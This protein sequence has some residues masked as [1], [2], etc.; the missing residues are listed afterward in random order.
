MEIPEN[1]NTLG[2]PLRGA[3]GLLLDGLVVYG[4]LLIPIVLLSALLLGLQLLRPIL[5]NTPG[6]GLLLA[7]VSGTFLFASTGA[8]AGLVM[9]QQG[10]LRAGFG[11][12]IG[13]FLSQLMP[14]MFARVLYQLFMTMIALPV[15]ITV[16]LGCT[17]GWASN[18]QYLFF[19]MIGVGILI[20]VMWSWGLCLRYCLTLPVMVAEELPADAAIQRSQELM[21]GHHGLV[22]QLLLLMGLLMLLLGVG[23]Y[24]LSGQLRELLEVIPAARLILAVIPAFVLHPLV[25]VILGLLYLD[26]R[27]AYD[28]LMGLA[29][30]ELIAP[31]GKIAFA[32]VPWE[33]SAEFTAPPVPHSQVAF[34]DAPWEDQ[35]PTRE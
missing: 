12:L 15:L 27:T 8:I 14:M 26:R 11:E 1:L 16:I 32:D 5:G 29:A 23:L 33:E 7:I 21:E 6:V 35:D 30:P 31:V 22:S 20:G 13:C 4:K 28:R 19:G 10:G 18:S 17:L 34:A 2:R 3:R 24:Q 25:G 9:R